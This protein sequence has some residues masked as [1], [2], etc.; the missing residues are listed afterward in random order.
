MRHLVAG[1][2]WKAIAVLALASVLLTA[3]APAAFAGSPRVGVSIGVGPF[4]WGP[5][6]W[7]YY[8]PS[9]YYYPY[10]Y[11]DPYWYPYWPPPVVVHEPPVYVQ[12]PSEAPAP[13]D[14][15]YWY[16]CASAREYYPKVGQCPEAWIKVPPRPE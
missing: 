12:R 11:W 4:W 10:P 15:P 5:P 16:Y 14:G 2:P 9:R 1:S 7:P 6:Y 8:P 3:A 13:P